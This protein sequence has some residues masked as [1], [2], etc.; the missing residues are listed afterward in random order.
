MHS[1]KLISNIFFNTCSCKEKQNYNK[2]KQFENC[3]IF[4]KVR[5]L[6]Q[7]NKYY[8]E[9]TPSKIEK[10]DF[11]IKNITG[12][13]TEKLKRIPIISV[14]IPFLRFFAKLIKPNHTNINTVSPQEA[15]Y[16]KF[17]HE[18]TY[19][20]TG[21]GKDGRKEKLNPS[22]KQLFWEDLFENEPAPKNLAN[23]SKKNYNSSHG[24]D[25]FV[26]CAKKAKK[27]IISYK[28][29]DDFKDLKSDYQMI[30]GKK[31][32]QLEAAL[33]IYKAIAEKYPDYEIIVTG[34]S[35]GGSLAELVCSSPFAKQHGNTKGYSF[36]GYGAID[37]LSDCGKDFN[38][39]GNVT[40]ISS[41][42]DI[43]SNSSYHVG[44]EYYVPHKY[45][46]FI[47]SEEDK[48]LPIWARMLKYTVFL[49]FSPLVPHLINGRYHK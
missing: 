37:N 24:L 46:E 14:T 27:I 11:S 39:N 31:P 40:C 48:N 36:N 3:S 10:E 16:I 45:K 15:A 18:L 21:Q 34:Y 6:T 5:E 30:K 29:T 8:L 38:D 42:R 43:I 25:V 4:Q 49:L 47:F 17:C 35:L 33:I 32:E 2:S 20:A 44:K 41:C 1:N 26:Q 13:Y 28:D 22:Y 7:G 23:F 19:K 9:I 12:F